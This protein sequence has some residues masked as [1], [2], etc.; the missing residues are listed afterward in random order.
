MKIYKSYRMY[1]CNEYTGQLNKFGG[2]PTHLPP[3]WPKDE[4]GDELTFLCQLYCDG[5][6]LTVENTLCIQLYQWVK[7]GEEGSDPIIVPV[8]IGARE[9]LHGEGLRHPK[10]QEGDIKFEEVMEEVVE[11]HANATLEDENGLYLWYSKLKG[12]FNEDDITSDNFLGM[13]ND[14]AGCTPIKGSSPFNWGC[15]YKLVFYLNEAGNVAW[16]FY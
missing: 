13:I 12:W 9:N 14:G 16:D 15:G 6:K 7:N 11:K 8:S 5:E 2:V 10:L 3:T 4:S 1:F